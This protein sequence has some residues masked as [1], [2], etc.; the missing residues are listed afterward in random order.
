MRCWW[1]KAIITLALLLAYQGVRAAGASRT[2]QI[3]DAITE[4]DTDRAQHLLDR[5]AH[6]S[7]A[8]AFE[9]ARLAMYRGDCDTAAAI[10]AAPTYLASQEGA[11]L[12][13]L[14]HSCAGA[15]AG[16]V[17]V[18][19]EKHRVWIRLQDDADRV[20]V[21]FIVDVA[22]RSRR[23]LLRHLGVELPGLLRLE[24]VRD[25]F[26]L[27]AVTGLPVD[28]A[29]TT[30]TI[31]VARWG[32]VVMLSPRATPHGYPWEDTLAHEIT[33][34]VLT[35]MSGDRAPLWLQEGIAKREETR[36]R[37]PRPFDE[38]PY[39]DI[40][41]AALLAGQSVGIERLGPS[42]AM[43]P[44]AEA[45]RIAYAEVSSFVRYWI[46][47]TGEPALWLLLADLRGL[48]EHDPDKAMRSATGFEL[49][50]WKTRW[51][52]D[53][54]AAGAAQ[55]P[56]QGP[57]GARDPK[58]S[59]FGE[60]VRTHEMLRAVRLGDLLFDRG[61]S[62]AAAAYF[63]MALTPASKE[64]AVRWRAARALLDVDRAREA[65]EQL[66]VQDAIDGPFGPWFALRGRLLREAGDTPAGERS[67]G[68]GI[69]LDPLSEDVACEGYW[70]PRRAHESVARVP[71]PE[72]PARRA[73]C[74]QARLFNRQD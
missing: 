18:R 16:A 5:A 34:L 28:A 20:L 33:H 38:T 26:S 67:F 64:A 35:R 53:L 44:S 43:L 65:R 7:T 27:S 47:H 69:A 42:I 11:G 71:L 4:L 39:D 14:A 12:A 51:K 2:R 54:L 10:L 8:L 30:G 21:P 9:R 66:G 45:A 1:F 74:K 23:A 36:W 41:R 19:D 25:V 52:S 68:L 56:S 40:A 55:A 61:H 48:G 58:T 6:D 46:E 3:S 31:A 37:P 22:V 49:E 13:R 50:V 32:R 60:R 29:E 62:A 72:A 70:R 17:V 63:R 59:S 57:G 24:V 15:T 73:L